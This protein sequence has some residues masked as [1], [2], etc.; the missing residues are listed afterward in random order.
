VPRTGLLAFALAVASLSCA[1]RAFIDGRDFSAA[2]EGSGLRARWSPARPAVGDL[3]RLEADC[4]GNSAPLLAFPEGYPDSGAA[5]P[6]RVRGLPGSLELR[7]SFRVEAPGEY[8]LASLPLF[9]AKS[10]VKEGE[11]L[12][13]FEAQALWTGKGPLAP[14]KAAP[15]AAGGA[16]P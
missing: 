7:W 10:E 15:E 14:A 9:T 2:I 1:P 8:R 3:V 5:A 6:L 11:D 4:P 12:A 16:A 13:S